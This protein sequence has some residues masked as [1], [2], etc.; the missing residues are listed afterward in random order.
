MDPQREERQSVKSSNEPE[1]NSNVIRRKVP[2][3]SSS[4]GTGREQVTLRPSG[5]TWYSSAETSDEWAQRPHSAGSPTQE[6][7]REGSLHSSQTFGP[8]GERLSAFDQEPALGAGSSD[9]YIVIPSNAEPVEVED[10]P[11]VSGRDKDASTSDQVGT[12]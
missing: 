1:V 4:D 8:N 3:E 6:T 11:D 12:Y 2:T 7:Q 9:S 5:A 10:K